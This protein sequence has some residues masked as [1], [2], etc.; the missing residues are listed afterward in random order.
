M[1]SFATGLSIAL[2]NTAGIDAGL[3]VGAD[4]IRN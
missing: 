4:Q 1:K 3:A 2:E